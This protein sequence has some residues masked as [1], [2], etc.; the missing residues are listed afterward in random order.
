MWENIV[1]RKDILAPVVSTLRGRGPRR[2]RRSDA[3]EH[4][5]RIDKYLDSTSLANQTAARKALPPTTDKSGNRKMADCPSYYLPIPAQ[6]ITAKQLRGD[7]LGQSG[8]SEITDDVSSAAAWLYF[9][10]HDLRP[11]NDKVIFQR[12]PCDYP[13]SQWRRQR[14]SRVEASPYGRT[15]K[16]YVICVCFHCYGTSSNTLQGR[17]ANSHVDT[18]TI[19]PGL[20]D[21]VL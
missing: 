3:S 11:S 14:G 16:Y 10:M 9:G 1:G 19:Q 18:Q 13:C 20:W 5:H 8:T 17:R 12:A 4:R 15:S 7:W 2:P 21:F 6:P